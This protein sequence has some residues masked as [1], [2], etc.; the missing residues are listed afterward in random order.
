MQA[1]EALLCASDK[2]VAHV[3]D[4]RSG[5]SLHA[6]KDCR[7]C[8][9]GLCAA[10]GFVLAAESGRSFVHAWSWRK[11]QPRYRCQAPERVCCLA[12]TADGAHCVA[13]GQSGKLYLW[14]VATGRLLLSWDGHFKPVS[15]L[16]T[17]LCDGY[18]LSAGEDAIV[19]AWSFADLLH[20]AQSARDATGF[21][22]APTPYRTWTDHTLPV[23]ALC[24]G[25]CGQHDLIASASADQTVRVWR[26][27][28]ASVG[29]LHAIALPS[30]L[31]AIAAHPRHEALYAGALDGRVFAI[32]LLATPS[33]EGEGAFRSAVASRSGAVRA[34][35]VSV[36]GLRLYSV[37]AESGL[38]VW[39]SHTLA[40]IVVLQPTLTFEYITPLPP[41]HAVLGAAGD[42]AG[43]AAGVSAA[44]GGGAGAGVAGY[45]APPVLL[46]PL[47]KFSEPP[48]ASGGLEAT[49]RAM[50]C[51]ACD[52]RR[53]SGGAEEE[54]GAILPLLG[55]RPQVVSGVDG[56]GAGVRAAVTDVT[57][58]ETSEATVR[59][60]RGQLAQV[61][62]LNAE[63]FRMATDATLGQAAGADTRT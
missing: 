32:P 38:R 24:V 47:K 35:V 11:E 57:A 60:L 25:G 49:A 23:K 27:A 14:Q 40:L 53:G 3:L 58:A 45:A 6:L 59:L 63:L 48:L 12:C 18:L 4:A 46:S 16:A 33:P 34:L 41:I 10:G 31:S 37:G 21:A 15:A 19:L 55:R 52:L 54:E 22:P 36:D 2:G 20:A 8:A 7:P 62:Q 26:L 51:V 43:R 29:C 30:P 50:G 17:A 61:Q 5:A 13:G 56:I 39:D 28:D 1:T 9:G 42:G 44:D